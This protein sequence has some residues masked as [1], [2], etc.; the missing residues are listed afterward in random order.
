MGSFSS[1][2]TNNKRESLML[3]Y[4]VDREGDPMLMGEYET[5]VAPK[6]EGVVAS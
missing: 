5:P 2:Q 4:L 1:I 3:T 6:P